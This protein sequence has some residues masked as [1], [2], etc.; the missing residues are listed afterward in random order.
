[1][2]C[3]NFHFVKT[4]NFI[5]REKEERK[6]SSDPNCYTASESATRA[7]KLPADRLRDDYLKPSKSSN[8]NQDMNFRESQAPEVRSLNEQLYGSG[9]SEDKVP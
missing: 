5:K 8:K 2:V 7:K 6:L 3:L 9:R 4:E 1:M